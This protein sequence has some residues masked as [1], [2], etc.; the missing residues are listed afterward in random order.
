MDKSALQAI[1]STQPSA[2]RDAGDTVKSWGRRGILGGAV[3]GFIL[4]V[5]F[6]TI[7]L[8]SNAL[9]F[10]TVGTLIVAIIEGAVIAG[11]FGAFAAALYS[12][13]VI[14]GRDSRFG[15]TSPFGGRSPVSGWR[16]GDVPLADFPTKWAYPIPPAAP[17]GTRNDNGAASQR[18]QERCHD[19]RK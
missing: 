5:A 19:T 16:E 1:V 15:R 13:G 8:T 3:F 6:V 14:R 4:G 2:F 11:A 17:N 18:A 9:T 7:P 10:G 12:Q